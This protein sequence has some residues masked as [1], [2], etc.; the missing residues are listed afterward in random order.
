MLSPSVVA[1]SL[2]PHGPWPEL[3][4][5]WNALGQNTGW[6]FISSAE[7]LPP[8][9]WVPLLQAVL[10]LEPPGSPGRG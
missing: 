5:P 10:S 7:S 1:D 2:Q 9:S 3:L 6:G 4:F 8:G